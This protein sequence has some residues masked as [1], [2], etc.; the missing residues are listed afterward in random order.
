MKNYWSSV[1]KIVD[2]WENIGLLQNT[3]NKTELALVLEGQ[4][5]FNQT[6]R[7]LPESFLRMS[8]PL[9]VRVMKECSNVSGSNEPLKKWMEL[10]VQFTYDD[11]YSISDHME[12][13]VEYCESISNQIVKEL[14]KIK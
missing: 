5:L 12:E 7:L 4:F 1:E 14:N 2:K 13:E 10:N 8:L 11:A 9:W 6:P 3:P